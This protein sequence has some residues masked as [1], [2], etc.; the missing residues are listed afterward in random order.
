LLVV[1]VGVLWRRIADGFQWSRARLTIVGCDLTQ[2]QANAPLAAEIKE[3][4]DSLA[5][6]QPQAV[7][8]LLGALALRFGD[9]DVP[10]GEGVALER[11]RMGVLAVVTCLELPAKPEGIEMVVVPLKRRLQRAVKV[12]QRLV[13]SYRDP[14]AYPLS[15]GPAER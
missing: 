2:R 13:A 6:G 14:S 9:R 15:S 10:A 7:E 11:E 3:V 1:I 12:D 5:L 8:S 4:R